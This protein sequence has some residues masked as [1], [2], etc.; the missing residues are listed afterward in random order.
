MVALQWGTSEHHCILDLGSGLPTQG[1]F[2]TSATNAR[3]L[4]TDSDP[5]TV[6]YAQ[7]VL[8]DNPKTMYIQIDIRN[9]S[10]LLEMAQQHFRGE[11]R[12]AIGCIGIAYFLDDPTLRQL[13][14][15]LYDW[16]A[17]GSVM[18]M[19]FA[20]SDMSTANMRETSEHFKRVGAE[21]F[22]RDEEMIRQVVTPWHIRELK[23]LTTWLGMEHLIQEADHENTNAEMFGVMVEHR[24]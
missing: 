13:L 3:V 11:R 9:T 6:A 21:L 14:H 4:Y 10:A 22:F 24:G 1:H 12:V 23:P 16:A 18:A 17:P 15:T 8:K 7:E 20:Y 19:S 2:H 5:V